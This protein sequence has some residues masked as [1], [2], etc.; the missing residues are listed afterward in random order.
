[1]ELENLVTQGIIE[2][3]TEP[4]EW[5]API[6]VQPKKNDTVRLYVDLQKLNKFVVR[7]RWQS[8]TPLEV[9]ASLQKKCEIFHYGGGHQRIP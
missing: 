7:E 3:V 9:V 1:M 5:C 8:P 2:K 4:T 6:A